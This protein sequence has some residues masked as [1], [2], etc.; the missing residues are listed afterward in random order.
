MRRNDRSESRGS[1]CSFP[2]IARCHVA[3]GPFVVSQQTNLRQDVPS[4]TA[5]NEVRWNNCSRPIKILDWRKT[6]TR[7]WRWKVSLIIQQLRTSKQPKINKVKLQQRKTTFWKQTPAPLS[8]LLNDIW[9]ACKQT[10]KMCFKTLQSFSINEGMYTACNH[11]A[12]QRALS[13]ILRFHHNFLTSQGPELVIRCYCMS[14]CKKRYTVTQWSTHTT[15][16]H[17]MRLKEKQFGLWRCIS[18]QAIIWMRN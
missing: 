8:L 13:W 5:K 3:C 9:W 10:L 7:I 15:Q 6:E 14:C 17:K 4:V 1:K 2:I 18:F 11:T 12:Y 16:S